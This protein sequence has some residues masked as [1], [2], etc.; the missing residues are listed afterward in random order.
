VTKHEI[1][2]LNLEDETMDTIHQ[3]EPPLVVQPS[4]FFPNTEQDTYIV[5]SDVDVKMV[6]VGKKLSLNNMTREEMSKLMLTDSIFD[7]DDY[8]DLKNI[9]SV[10]YEKQHKCFYIC[11]NMLNGKLGFYVLRIAENDPFNGSLIIRQGN[12]LNF[13]DANIVFL[14]DS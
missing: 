7:I 13:E 9:K 5:G 1:F 14:N 11:A 2:N 8:Y 12:K 10:N 3:F 6:L 4:Y